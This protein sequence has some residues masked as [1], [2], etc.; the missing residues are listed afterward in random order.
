[1]NFLDIKLNPNS[2]LFSERERESSKSSR[3]GDGAMVL[4]KLSV[5]GRPT[6]LDKSRAR[7]YCARSMCGWGLFEY[8][9]SRLSFFFSFS[10]FGTRSDID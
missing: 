5:P 6:N 4:C 3:E 1:M 2:L 8:F 7:A 9:F 10:L